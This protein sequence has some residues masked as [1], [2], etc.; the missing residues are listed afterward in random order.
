MT[1]RRPFYY[2]WV[3]VI[4]AAAAMTA[5]LPGRTYGLGLIKEPLRADLRLDDLRFSVINALAIVLGAAVVLPVGRLIDRLGTRIMVTAVSLILGSSVLAMSRATDETSLAITLT[6]VR[7]FGQG[8]LSVVAIALVGKWFRQRIGQAMGVFTVLLGVGFVFPPFI[9]KPIIEAD[10]WRVAWAGVGYALF[11]FAL[12]GWLIARSTPEAVGVPPDAPVEEAAVPAGGMT[13]LEALRTPAFWVYTAAGTLLNLV[14][15]AVTLDNEQLLNER[16]LTGGQVDQTILAA[17]FVSG[18]PANLVAGWLGR[19]VALKKL[20]A[21][22]SVCLAA[23]LVAFPFV[24]S[25]PTAAAYASL[26]GVSG[27]VITVVYFAIYG[28]TYGRTHLG[29]IQAAVQVYSVLAS[30]VGPV[31]LSYC[32][33]YT[34]GTDPYF[35][36]FAAVAVVLAVLCWVVPPSTR[37]IASGVI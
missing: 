32:R 13:L 15:S 31:V 33:E 28:H 16:G 2:G 34:G 17:L 22:G 36:G 9:L 1:D 4:A 23:S 8:A 10:G 7:G 21:V 3:N 14:F 25:L 27:G 12:L 24:R 6:L 19:R 37:P 5:T 30:A 11:A 35:F 26:L 29:A 20:L 18:L